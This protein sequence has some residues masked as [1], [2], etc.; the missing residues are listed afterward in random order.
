MWR[1]QAVSEDVSGVLHEQR[2][3]FQEKMLKIVHFLDVFVHRPSAGR[4]QEAGRDWYRGL[5]GREYPSGWQ[6]E[7][8]RK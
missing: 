4:R 8:L 6:P 1:Q 5:L 3:S 2:R 7:E